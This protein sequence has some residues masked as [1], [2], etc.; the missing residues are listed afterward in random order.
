VPRKKLTDLV[1]EK[2][3]P[4]ESGRVEYFDTTFPGLAFRITASGHRSWSVFYRIGGRQRRYTIGP[5]LLSNRL[6]PAK[7]LQRYSIGSKQAR[8][9]QRRSALGETWFQERT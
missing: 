8:T 1:V 5:T 9:P 7:P 4:P 2:E 6:T 3:E